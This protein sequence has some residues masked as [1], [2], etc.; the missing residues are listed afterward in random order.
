MGMASKLQT[1][2]LF[3]VYIGFRTCFF[4]IWGLEFRPWAL[5]VFGV[6][7]SGNGLQ[8][9]LTGIDGIEMGLP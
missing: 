7:S 4:W 2:I 3:R 1:T 9:L 5:S 6:Q 8:G